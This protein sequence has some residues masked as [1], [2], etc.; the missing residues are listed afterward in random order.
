[1]SWGYWA[2]S[3]EKEML[4]PQKNSVYFNPICR[5]SS[6]T[7]TDRHVME[8]G[9]KQLIVLLSFFSRREDGNFPRFRGGMDMVIHF[10]IKN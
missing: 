7:R 8:A 1:M 5:S 9:M 10:A 2:V 4:A 6:S 3:V